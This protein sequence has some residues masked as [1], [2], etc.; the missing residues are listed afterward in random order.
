MTT[1]MPGI[2]TT[3]QDTFSALEVSKDTY[4][5]RVVILARTGSDSS[6]DTNH[7]FDAKR[8]TSLN[9]VATIHGEES[10][11]YEAFYHAQY[12]GCVDIWL[13]PLPFT[14]DVDRETDLETAYEMLYTIR[15]SIV[16]PY[17]RGAKISI[18]SEGVVTRSVPVEGS[19]DFADG[20]YAD[21]S[22]Y[23]ESLA[24]AC[25]SLSDQE[26]ICIGIIGC[27]AFAS[28]TP[29]SMVTNIGTET[30]LGTFFSD[31][32]NVST[33]TT[34]DNGKFVNVVMTEVETAG[35]GPWA[36]RKGVEGGTVYYRSNGALNYAGLISKLSVSE[37]PTN[38]NVSGISNIAYKLSKNQTLACI[39]KNIV[40]FNVSNG[41]VR[42]DD[43][44]TY[45]PVGS[46][47]TRLSTLRICAT[48]DDMVR[49]IGAKFIGR[50]MRI[51]TRN[52]FST[53]IA[54][55]LESLLNAG[56]ILDADYR[57]TYDGPNYTA[58]VAVVIVPAWELRNIE[59]TI[60]V[61]FQGIN[62]SQSS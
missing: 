10:E 46:D 15:P 60:Q 32:P 20:A 54:S 61:T 45:A 41:V 13:C 62:A 25:A 24:D 59:L 44:M 38:K 21:V 14:S 34:P 53:N 52:S 40:T 6:S 23:L 30:S 4:A 36:W 18:D 3:L 28:V 43:A 31:V 37:A 12:S 47:F 22:T 5:D 7:L 8:Y 11:L 51:E 2:N 57:V 48:V 27:S 42:V 55:G 17:G 39:S 29:S 19:G 33:F 16:V 56:V 49:R 35:M 58:Y 9:D 26:R 50:G 1:T